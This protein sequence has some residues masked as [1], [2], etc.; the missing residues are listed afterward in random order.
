MSSQQP[1]GGSKE[2]PCP[3]DTQPPLLFIPASALVDPS[4]IISSRP[5]ANNNI[6]EVVANTVRTVRAVRESMANVRYSAD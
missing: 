6:A 3:I 2:P 1:Q 4:R 5:A